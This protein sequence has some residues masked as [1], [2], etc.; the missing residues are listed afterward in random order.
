MAEAGFFT[1]LRGIGQGVC[2]LWE[3]FTPTKGNKTTE[4][5]YLS[6]ASIFAALKQAKLAYCP[7]KRPECAILEIIST[8]GGLIARVD[9]DLEGL[10]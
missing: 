5:A 6:N 10:R 4:S 7:L 8:Y 2:P 9:P 3:R 1:F